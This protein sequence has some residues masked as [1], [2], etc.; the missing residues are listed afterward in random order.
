MIVG[1]QIPFLVVQHFKMSD[2]DGG[3]YDTEHL[4]SIRMRGE[5]LHDCITTWDQV[6]AGVA[7]VPDESTLQALLLRNLR[8]CKPVE[9]DIAFYDRLPGNDSNKSYGYLMRCARAVVE[10]NR[11]HC[12]RDEMSRSIGGNWV[13]PAG[14][15]VTRGK[16]GK[17]RVPVET[18]TAAKATRRIRGPSQKDNKKDGRSS[19]ES[20]GKSRERSGDSYAGNVRFASCISEE[21]AKPEGIALESTTSVPFLSTW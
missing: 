4:F 5:T 12:Y 1:L 15:G 18:E 11:L 17:A 3:V 16:R 14:K 8:Q 13:N 10:R 19:S 6:L 20:R 21:S 7:K 9:Q 2:M